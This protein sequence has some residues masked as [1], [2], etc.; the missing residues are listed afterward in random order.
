MTM[1][2]TSVPVPLQTPARFCPPPPVRAH[3]DNRLASDLE[4]SLGQVMSDFEETFQR[5]RT[6]HEVQACLSDGAEYRPNARR[7]H[8]LPGPGETLPLPA[9]TR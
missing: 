6:R 5:S 2:L 7:F 9:T 8:S 4:S 3:M 1:D